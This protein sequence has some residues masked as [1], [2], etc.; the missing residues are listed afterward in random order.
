MTK[1]ILSSKWTKAVLFLL[2]LVPAIRIAV[3]VAVALMVLPDRAIATPHGFWLDLTPNPVE[4]ITHYTGDWTIRFIL[5]TLTVTPLRMLLNQP[6]LT[7][8]RRMLGLY[9]FFYGMLHLTTWMWLSSG[10]DLS[11][12]WAD[13]LK[14]W[15]ITV[16]MAGLLAMV[17]LAITSTAGWVR[18]L[19]YKRWQNLHR[20]IYFTAL[21]GVIHYYLLVKSDIRLPVMYGVILAILMLFRLKT[22]L[23]KP[24]K[25]TPKRVP[26]P[27][28]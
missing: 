15:Y 12:M 5:I 16:G 21:A 22:W 11:A 24:T 26:A 13:V 14:R 1:K 19:G 17:P 7:R 2:C 18:R 23:K 27:A 20:L 9:A 6:Q 25:P 10:W 4:F 28:A 8:F 3:P